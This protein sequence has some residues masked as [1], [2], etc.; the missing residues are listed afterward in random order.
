MPQKTCIKVLGALVHLKFCREEKR[1]K[2]C[3]RENW[4]EV[5]RGRKQASS[6]ATEKTGFKFCKEE[7]RPQV[8]QQRKLDL[9]FARK[10]TG[11]KFC[12]GE[13]W[14]QAFQG[15]KPALSGENLFTIL[16]ASPACESILL[17]IWL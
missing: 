9:S 15:R 12:M 7:N 10:K 6:F 13:N 16:F 11:L 2:F 8:L 5:L 17:V 1:F 3:N 4:I 14:I